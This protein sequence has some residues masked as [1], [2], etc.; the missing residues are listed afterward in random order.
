MSSPARAANSAYDSNFASAADM[1]MFVTMRVNKQLFGVPVRYV[2]DVLR[3]Q[4]ITPIPLAPGEVAGSLNLRGRIVTVLDLH[5]RLRLPLD[6]MI[7]AADSG[8]FVVVE[9]RGELYSLMVDS[10]GEVLNISAADIEKTPANLD[11]AWKEVSSGIYKLDGELLVIMQVDS[12]L[13]I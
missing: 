12:L 5:K 6:K 1:H 11:G 10:V 3:R 7:A 2:R 8:M 13:K 4:R 9:H